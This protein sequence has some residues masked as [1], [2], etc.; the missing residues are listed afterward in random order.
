MEYLI[1]G[2]LMK[3]ES[4][5]LRLTKTVIDKIEPSSDKDQTFYRD[6]LLKGFAL[7]VTSNGIKSFI[8]ESRVNG[9]VKRI[10]LGKYGVITTEEARKKAKIM[11]GKIANGIDPVA[12]KKHKILNSITLSNVMQDYLKTRKDLKIRT[13]NDYH[14]VLQQ[15]IPDWLNK[16]IVNITREMVAKRHAD[17]GKQNSKARANNAMRVLR[18]LFNFATHEYLINNDHSII[19]F[20]PVQYLSHTRG[21]FKID[22]KQTVIK[23]HQLADWYSGV[24]KLL[25]FGEYSKMMM[26]RDYL[27]LLIFTGM[28]KTE[29]ASIKWVDVDLDAKTFTLQDTKNREKH[30]LPM[31]NSIYEIFI[32]RRQTKYNDFVFPAKSQSGYIQEPKKIVALVVQLSGVTFTLHD[33]RR[34]FATI[35]EGLN[36][37]AYALKRLLNHKMSNDVTAGYVMKD[38]ERLRNPMQQ[39]ND[40][41]LKHMKKD[42]EIVST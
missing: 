21:W 12:E 33:L 8:V 23:V 18:A 5:I 14:Y 42:L 20:N 34:T 30:T 1:K 3:N 31:S 28:R 9:K 36:L 40:F 29:T 25:E 22:R 26:W 41:L 38:A 39:I 17:Y 7:R 16:P 13:I 10:T 35:A 24:N 27:L 32:R 11:L 6:D 19:T 4:K 2:C 15:V 37:P